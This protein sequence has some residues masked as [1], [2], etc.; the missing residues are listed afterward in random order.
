MLN[1][2]VY[3]YMH[4]KSL[5]IWVTSY[6]K[7]EISTSTDTYKSKFL[8]YNGNFYKFLNYFIVKI[9]SLE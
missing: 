4:R 2:D 9:G 7:K 8:S 6:G 1:K 3:Y 5:K